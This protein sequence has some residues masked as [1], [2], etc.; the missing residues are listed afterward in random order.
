M[1][2]C[3]F[4]GLEET[5]VAKVISGPGVYICNVCVATCNDI[6]GSDAAHPQP[7]RLPDTETMTD[8]EILARIPRIAAVQSQV[9]HNLHEW[10]GVLRT[11]NVTWTAIGGALGITRQSAWERFSGEE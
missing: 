11:R 10:V 2:N 7:P 8:V 1:V 6:L 5:A 3:S 9:E 4:C